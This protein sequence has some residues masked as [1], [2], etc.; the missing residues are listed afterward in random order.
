MG[1]VARVNVGDVVGGGARNVS[2][3]GDECTVRNV[4]D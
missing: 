4:G 3:V 1:R 2:H